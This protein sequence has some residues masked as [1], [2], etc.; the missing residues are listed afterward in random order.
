[1]QKRKA[2]IELLAPARD[3]ET[4]IQAILHGADAVYIG[5]Q[6]HGARAAVGNSTADIGRVVTFAHQFG[7]KV[8]LVSN[9]DI[10]LRQILD[11]LFIEKLY[12]LI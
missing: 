2:Q 4:A 1:M 7:A 12:I 9:L 10:W 6:S 3:A 8:Y 5:P 11:Y